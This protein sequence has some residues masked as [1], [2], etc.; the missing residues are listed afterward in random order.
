MLRYVL[1][2]VL[3]CILPFCAAQTYVCHLVFVHVLVLYVSWMLVTLCCICVSI[4]QMLCVVVF[5][6]GL[7]L[8]V[9]CCVLLLCGVRCWVVWCCTV[10]SIVLRAALRV[11]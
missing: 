5:Y 8:V 9:L 7:C 6:C 11:G 2:D 3:Y 1:R 10:H 4:Y